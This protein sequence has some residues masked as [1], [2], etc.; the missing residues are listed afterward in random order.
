MVPGGLCLSLTGHVTLGKSLPVSGTIS[1]LHSVTLSHVSAALVALTH[2]LGSWGL[3]VGGFISSPRSVSHPSGRAAPA[4][5]VLLR[6]DTEDG[7]DGV[8]K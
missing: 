2:S 6:R 4:H 7:E 8:G 5:P 3:G 1:G